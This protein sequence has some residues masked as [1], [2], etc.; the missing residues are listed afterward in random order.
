[1][2]ASDARAPFQPNT[3]TLSSLR[4]TFA[5]CRTLVRARAS[6]TAAKTA[7]GGFIVNSTP[8]GKARISGRIGNR[9]SRRE[10]AFENECWHT[11][12]RPLSATSPLAYEE[13]GQG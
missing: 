8:V 5:R 1:V 4:G 3:V 9:L 11:K 10:R 13:R 12:T 7:T 6:E 2:F